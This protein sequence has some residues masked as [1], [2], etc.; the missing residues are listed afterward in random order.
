MS[1][2]LCSQGGWIEKEGRKQE[3]RREKG[4]SA[5]HAPRPSALLLSEQ[6]RSL[7]K[8]CDSS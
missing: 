3:E 5:P 6:E 7:Y 1:Y 2:Q 4:S 8:E